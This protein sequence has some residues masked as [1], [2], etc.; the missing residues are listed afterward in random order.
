[1]TVDREVTLR[2]AKAAQL[3][4]APDQ[5]DH[6][7]DSI[8]DI[9]DFCALVGDLD[10]TGTPDFSWKMKKLPSRRPDAPSDWCDRDEF[11]ASAPAMDGNFFRVPKIN[12]EE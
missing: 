11:K 5:I 12:A 3:R 7:M 6:M 4:I 10:C 8:N 2:M 1:M 9:L